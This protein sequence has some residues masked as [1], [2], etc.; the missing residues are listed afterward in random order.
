VTIDQLEMIEAIVETGSFQ[1]AAKKVHKSQPSL[2]VGVKKIEEL[3]DIK[4]FS[5]ENYRP[6]LT[7]Q[8]ELFY[9]AAKR[10]LFSFRGLDRLGKELGLGRESEIKIVMDPLVNI[11]KLS[12]IFQNIEDE[13][14]ETPIHISDAIL[15]EPVKMLLNNE[16]DFAIGH[17]SGSQNPKVESKPF[18]KIKLQAVISQKLIGDGKITK[19]V[20]DHHP[21]I[22]VQLN[23]KNFSNSTVQSQRK[24]FVSNHAL[25]E[26]MILEGIGWGKVH[27]EKIK[28]AVSQKSL[29][30]ISP[31]LIPIQELEIHFIRNKLKPMGMIAKKIWESL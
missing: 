30:K 8:G 23:S 12:K 18:C 5:R 25:K 27:I 19:K 31:K 14:K 17:L 6:S 2:S 24:W 1:A 7:K 20:L 9:Q 10:T 26:E 22:V 21:N 16:C 13:L 28:E 15:N 3:Y 29:I 11:S 4:L